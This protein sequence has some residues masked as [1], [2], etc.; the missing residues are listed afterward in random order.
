M[1]SCFAKRRVLN[2]YI[3]PSWLG[4]VST[5]AGESMRKGHVRF[6][7]VV[8]GGYALGGEFVNVLVDDVR[9][10]AIGQWDRGSWGQASVCLLV[11][12]EDFL[13]AGRV[14]QGHRDGHAERSLGL[15]DGT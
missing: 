9:V 12:L 1:R 6:A 5:I 14:P 10:G 4:E 11:C 3:L 2:Q 13:L 8:Q 7:E 15:V